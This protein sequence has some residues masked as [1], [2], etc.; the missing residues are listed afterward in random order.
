MLKY[1]LL[2]LEI[3]FYFF[4]A[5]AGFKLM[6]IAEK[7]IMAKPRK[8]LFH[9]FLQFSTVSLAELRKTFFPLLMSLMRFLCFSETV[10]GFN[11]S[12][13][14]GYSLILFS[15]IFK[16]LLSEWTPYWCI[17]SSCMIGKSIAKWTIIHWKFHILTCLHPHPWYIR[18]AGLLISRWSWRQF[19][20][21]KTWVLLVKL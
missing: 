21:I 3:W 5:F 18:R 10:I 19:S 16:L 1:F 7:D 9:T 8:S 6:L 20:R 12:Q 4:Y 13:F 2:L 15:Y 17:I 11:I 14:V